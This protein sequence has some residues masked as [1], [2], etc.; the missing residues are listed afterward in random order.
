MSDPRYHGG[1]GIVLRKLDDSSALTR[2][3]DEAG[4]VQEFRRSIVDEVDWCEPDVAATLDELNRKD[5]ARAMSPTAPTK[6]RRR[7]RF[8]L[9]AGRAG[10]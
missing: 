3:A 1:S 7:Y 4:I 5:F 2:L 8:S 9:A 10:G 6:N